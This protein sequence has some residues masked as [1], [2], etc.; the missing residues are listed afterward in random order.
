M[1]VKLTLKELKSIIHEEV[2]RLVRNSAGFYSVGIGFPSK[3]MELPPPGLGD[4]GGEEKETEKERY[5]KNQK[6]KQPQWIAR[7]DSRRI[8]ERR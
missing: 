5:V 6:E 8:R 1:S 7:A 3:D 2:D 4:E